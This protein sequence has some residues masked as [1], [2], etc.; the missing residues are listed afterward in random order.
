ME[1]GGFEGVLGVRGGGGVRLGF[2][3][4]FYSAC[5]GGVARSL[6]LVA[7]GGASD[8]LDW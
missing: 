8:I 2:S 7:A 3:L 4:V 6:G 1:G 5:G